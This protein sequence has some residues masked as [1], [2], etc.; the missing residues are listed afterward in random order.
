[1]A[2]GDTFDHECRFGVPWPVRAYE[3][4]VPPLRLPAHDWQITGLDVECGYDAMALR[5]PVFGAAAVAP[6]ASVSGLSTARR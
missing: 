2:E 1:M 3:E 6:A 4:V 5:R